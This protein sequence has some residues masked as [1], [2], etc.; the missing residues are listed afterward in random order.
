MGSKVF[1]FTTTREYDDVVAEAKKKGEKVHMARIHGLIYEKNYQLK[2]DD[3]ARK[4]KGRG[5]LLGDQVK[6]QNMEAALFQD[7]GNSPATFDAS[8]WADYYGCLP[9]H[10]VQMAD[11]IQA[12]I[13]A[14]LS[15][16]Y[17]VELPDEAWHPSAN[18]H[19]FRRPVCRL[20]K[21]LYGHPDAGTMWEQHCHTAVQKVGF[22]PS[23]RP[24]VVIGHLR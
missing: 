4:F 20:V 6:D 12:Y 1:D 24:Q 16:V 18:R 19:K 7:L 13:Q 10:D 9:G 22:K 21:A 11:A 5:V 3:P 14:K 8:R 2:E 15:G 23:S 17:W